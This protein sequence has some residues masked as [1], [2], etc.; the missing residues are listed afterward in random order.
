[1]IEVSANRTEQPEPTRSDEPSAEPPET[2]SHHERTSPL[3]LSFL[4]FCAICFAV[5]VFSAGKRYREEYAQATEGWRVGTSRRVE[6]TLV[7]EDRQRLACASDQDFWGLRCGGQ[8]DGR[9]NADPDS[10][11]LQPFN[12]V[13]NELFLGAG[14]W[15]AL[16]LRKRPLPAKRFTVV[17]NYHIKGIVKSARVRFSPTTPFAPLERTVTVGTLT[18]CLVPR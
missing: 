18:D 9:S 17:C 8:R 3:L 12:T 13:A 15:N 6:I 10:L 11:T 4:L 16:D 14:L 5:W 1:M 2:P 7:K